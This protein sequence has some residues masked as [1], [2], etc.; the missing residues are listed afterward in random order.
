MTS[1]TSLNTPGPGSYNLQRSFDKLE[2]PSSKQH[3]IRTI[4]NASDH[5][6]NAKKSKERSLSKESGTDN[7][8]SFL[9][10]SIKNH[11][12]LRENFNKTD[13]QTSASKKV[14]K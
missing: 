5:F 14:K 13:I 1:S 9:D 2:L 12:L 11:M 10:A 7:D 3:Y 8:H 6:K 4:E